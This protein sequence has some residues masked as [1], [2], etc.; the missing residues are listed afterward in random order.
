M[1]Q[2]LPTV[3]SVVDGDLA[4]DLDRESER[5]S[6]LTLLS[7]VCVNSITK[8]SPPYCGIPLF[9]LWNLFPVLIS[10][11]LS[12]L[13]FSFVVPSFLSLTRSSSRS[14]SFSLPD[15]PM[16]ICYPLLL[17][18]PM[19]S[20][21]MNFDQMHPLSSLCLVHA[22][23]TCGRVPGHLEKQSCFKPGGI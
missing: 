11:C 22:L 12:L 7:W 10:N 4:C 16:I 6:G 19:L 8:H 18:L 23:V 20:H 14:L 5:V 13:I 2:D 17:V 21:R 3:G 15:L 9:G 1:S